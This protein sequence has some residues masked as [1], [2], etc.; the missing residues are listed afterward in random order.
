MVPLEA[1]LIGQAEANHTIGL[2]HE[3]EAAGFGEEER[4]REIPTQPGRFLSAVRLR[5]SLP[6]RHR[7][8]R[9]DL[10]QDGRLCRTAARLR[11]PEGE[12]DATLGAAVLPHEAPT[13]AAGA[14][15][16]ADRLPKI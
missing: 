4:A 16:V 12:W 7:R 8:H 2:G 13:H 14:T 11:V 1:R 6:G 15:L 5:T 3:V 9:I 10:S